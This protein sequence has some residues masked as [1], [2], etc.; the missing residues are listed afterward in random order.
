MTVPCMRV[1][2][3]MQEP[4]FWWR[5]QMR[6]SLFASRGMHTHASRYSREHA[7]KTDM[8][9]KKL[10]NKVIIF[11]FVQKNLYHCFLNEGWTTDVT[12]CVIDTFV[13]ILPPWAMIDSFV[14]VYRG[15]F[16]GFHKKYLNLCSEDERR[17]C[18]FLTNIWFRRNSM[19]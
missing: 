9:E 15:T 3:L 11:L 8:E 1:V 17:S 7:S 6:C 18:G 14:V 5:T 12:V 10:F 4:L 13:S 19:L 2:L 16:F